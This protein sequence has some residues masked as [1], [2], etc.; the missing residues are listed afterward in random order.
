MRA[1]GSNSDGWVPA[2]SWEAAK[3]AH[4]GAFES[5]METVRESEDPEMNEERSRKLWPWDEI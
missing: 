5:W 3:E 4:R 1:L 2:E